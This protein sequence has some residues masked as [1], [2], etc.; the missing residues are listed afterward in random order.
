[1]GIVTAE[2][3][4]AFRFEIKKSYADDKANLFPIVRVRT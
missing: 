3:E 1:V 4:L 2:G